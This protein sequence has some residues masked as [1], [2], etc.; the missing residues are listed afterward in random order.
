MGFVQRREQISREQISGDCTQ[1]K[2]DVD[3]YNT[4]NKD[5]PLIQLVLDFTDDVAER[6]AWHGDDKEAA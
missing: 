4:M 1:L 5:E 6:E 2:T 3:V